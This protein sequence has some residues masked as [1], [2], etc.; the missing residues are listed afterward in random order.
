M[1]TDNGNFILDWKFDRVHKWSE[2]NT[3]IKMIPGNMGG[4]HPLVTEPSL[5]TFAE[6]AGKTAAFATFLDRPQAGYSATCDGGARSR[7]LGISL[8]KALWLCR[9]HAY[10]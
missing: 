3:A 10:Q 2:V 7:E 4:V 1:V 9:S 8:R 6:A 5:L